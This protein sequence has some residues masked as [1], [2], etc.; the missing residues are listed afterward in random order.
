MNLSGMQRMLSQ[1]IAK[2]YLMLGTDI[3]VEV[4]GKQLDQSIATFESNFQLLSEYAPT[5]DIA[6]ALEHAGQ[7]WQSYRELALSQPTPEQ[8]VSMLALSDQLLAQSE[9]VVQQLQ[10]YNNS[11]SAKLVNLSGRQRMLSQRIAKLYLALSWRLPIAELPQ[12]FT[13]TVSEF[14]QALLILQKAP[15]NTSE[16]NTG[17][18]KVDAQWRFSQAGF[19]LS[20]QSRY[21]PTVIVTTTDTLTGQMNNLTLQYEKVMAAQP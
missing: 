6:T 7:T 18:Q 19:K 1:R 21:V 15:Q 20:E 14:D 2:N 13:Q 17:L 10:T 4:A 3:R 12:Q 9:A 11:T 5:A 16:I 8:A